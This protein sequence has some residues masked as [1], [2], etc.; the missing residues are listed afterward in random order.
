MKKKVGVL[1]VVLLLFSLAGCSTD[2]KAGVNEILPEKAEPNKVVEGNGIYPGIFTAE[3]VVELKQAEPKKGLK[4]LK[5]IGLEDMGGQGVTLSLYGEAEQA[6]EV[7]AFLEGQGKK[8]ALGQ[9]SSYGLEQLEV[10]QQDMN[11]DGAKELVV[12][13]S[14]GA[15]AVETT[16]VG[17]DST[18]KV[19]QQLL[20][21]NYAYGVDL[22]EDGKMEILSESRGSLPSF[23]LLFRW[24]G[25]QYEGMDIA[26]VTHN[27][28][29]LARAGGSEYWLEAGKADVARYYLY[30]D[31]NLMEYPDNYGQWT[32]YILPQSHKR[33]LTEKDLLDLYASDVELAYNE[34]Y[35]RHGFHFKEDGLKSYFGAKAWYQERAA[36][37][38]SL[39][40]NTEKKNASFLNAYSGVLKEHF[41]KAEGPSTQIDLNGDGKE[42]KITLVCQPGDMSYRLGV[43]NSWIEGQGDHLDGILYI[44][45]I[46]DRDKYL[47]LVMTESGPSRDGAAYFYYY[48]G[49]KLR[50]MG[51]IQGGAYAMKIDGSGLFSGKTRGSILH[52]WFYTEQY[53]LNRQHKLE[54]V[55]QQYY[56]MNTVVRLKAPLTLLEGPGESKKS[57]VLQE[58]TFGVITRTDNKQWCEIEGPKGLKG[59][60]EVQDNLC[61]KG[62][63][64]NSSEV[65]EGLNFT[66]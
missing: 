21:T 45:N 66:D 12:R 23:V 39:L 35:A 20:K 5:R 62:T 34:I 36:Y 44:A 15:P 56:R 33:A 16:I 42:D 61:I 43:N 2:K 25:T 51:R 59:W 50:Y 31:G 30:K 49:S 11:N 4:Q 7:F 13:G 47:E 48:D 57:G 29:A 54:S 26:A 58:G 32:D 9:V 52:T 18:R 1:L 40:S 53:K 17:Y 38:D 37:T 60:F 55:P 8:W 24:T 6:G 41:K 10:L 28:Y 19:W 46:D 22:D 63:G 64:R 65:F 27:E 14:Q 3:P